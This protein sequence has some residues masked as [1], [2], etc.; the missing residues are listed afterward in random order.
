MDIKELFKGVAVIIDDKVN[1]N[2]SKNEDKIL[3]IVEKLEHEK[4]PLLK[5][6]SIPDN[7]EIKNFQNISFILLDWELQP[8]ITDSS[9][10]S[11][12]G[13]TETMVIKPSGYESNENIEFIKYLRQISFIPIFIF[14]H[15][16]SNTIITKL[17]EN[18][19]Y[20]K[21]ASN[22]IF[23]KAKNDLISDENTLFN[24]IE[25]W[26]K[27]TPSIYVL[28]EWEKSLNEAKNKL[29]WDF[30]NINHKWPSV[31]Q[32]TFTEDG[33]DVNYE[34]GNFI[35][36]NI[37]A[38]TDPIQFDEDILKLEDDDLTKEEIRKVLEVERFIKNDSLPDMPF[39]GDLFKIYKY[40][41][42]ESATSEKELYYI[43]IRPDCDIAIRNGH[44][45][46]QLFCLECT[47][48]DETKI[49]SGDPNQIIFDKG[50][51]IGKSVNTYLPFIDGKIFEIRFRNLKI[52]KWEQELFP[53]QSGGNKRKFKFA[54]IGRILPP[55]ITAIQ[56][57]YS[58]YLQRQGLPAIPEKAIKD[59]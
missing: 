36:K 40:E 37:M 54:R 43:N 27:Q 11:V 58:F 49:N 9:T 32:K 1:N 5:Y 53:K 26:L 13:T 51:F 7:D 34:L 35:F 2:E 15:L 55:Y 20:K 8:H 52:F 30:Y 33:S 47:I 39:T 42:S 46:P 48:I 17:E 10:S 44:T 18:D 28:K 57:K 45:N 14:S 38:R 56:Q 41:L 16:D 22:Y 24:E 4:I 50:T 3:E 29:F 31:L 23:V 25:N 12:T 6:E 19:L 21:E 59:D